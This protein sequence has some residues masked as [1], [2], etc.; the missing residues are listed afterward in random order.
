VGFLVEPQNQGRRFVNSL[1]SKPVGRFSLIW[2]QNR[3]R[4][5]SQFGPQNQQLRF[6]D[7]GLKITAMVSWFRTQNQTDFGL[8]VAPQNQRREDGVGHAPRSGGLR[9][10]EASHARV[11]QSALKTDGGATAG[12]ARDTIAEVASGSS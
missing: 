4:L 5:V 9:R 8:S 1:A 7:L 10:L 2:P 12:G 3:W 11:S 6:S